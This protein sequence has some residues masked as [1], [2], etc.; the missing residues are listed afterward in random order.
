MKRLFVFISIILL[1]GS[2]IAMSMDSDCLLVQQFQ[3]NHN[4]DQDQDNDPIDI[5]YSDDCC[6]SASHFVGIYPDSTFK[7]PI[8]SSQYMPLRSGILSSQ[9][10]QPATPPPNV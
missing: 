3:T 7:A 1:L 8:I 4:L 2:N 9:I 5:D 6:H 10:Y